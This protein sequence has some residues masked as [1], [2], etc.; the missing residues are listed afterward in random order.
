MTE[1]A[2]IFAFDPN[3]NGKFDVD[4]RLL[5]PEDVLSICSSLVISIATN[6][7]TGVEDY[8]ASIATDND[9]DDQDSPG[10][11]S[12]D[13]NGQGRWPQA[14]NATDSDLEENYDWSSLVCESGGEKNSYY[15]VYTASTSKGPIVQLAHYSVKEYLVSDRIHKGS[16]V[17][18]GIDHKAAHYTIG[19]SCL[20][21]LL[22]CDKDSFRNPNQFSNQYPLANYSARYWNEHFL[23]LDDKSDVPPHPLAI[24]LF[25][26]KYAMK[27]WKALC[28]D[29]LLFMSYFSRFNYDDSYYDDT[30]GDDDFDGD[31]SGG[32]ESDQDGP[33][34]PYNLDRQ[35]QGSQL[36]YAVLTGLKGLVRTMIE[37]HG[38][39]EAR[40]ARKSRSTNVSKSDD[41]LVAVRSPSK[42]AYINAMGSNLR[43]PLRAA[44]EQGML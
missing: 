14:S 24:E 28:N 33:V 20:S 5:D 16:A 10:P 22:I 19:V 42:R 44:V 37:M 34:R 1:L 6:T 38:S 17:F 13:D 40:R 3:S 7:D 15:G 30:D 36:Y 4:S 32:D 43:T 21:C 8:Q 27:S 39:W 2:E 26:S 41:G 12:L 18:F 29:E 25:Q 23:F 31:D 9:P 11:I 35:L